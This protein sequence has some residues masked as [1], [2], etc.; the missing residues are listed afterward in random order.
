[1]HV[2]EVRQQERPE[3]GPRFNNMML[4]VRVGS[5]GIEGW[6]Y[7]VNTRAPAIRFARVQNVNFAR[8]RNTALRDEH[9]FLQVWV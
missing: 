4:R 2:L 7:Q 1:M 3:P 9:R 6:I 8:V 5:T